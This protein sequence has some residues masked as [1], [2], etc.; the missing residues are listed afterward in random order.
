VSYLKKHQDLGLVV[1]P[2]P[3]D[4][5]PVMRQQLRE[6]MKRK[7]SESIDGTT[8]IYDDQNEG[9]DP[10]QNE[11]ERNFARAEAMLAE[12]ED[13]ED[14]ELMDPDDQVP[15]GKK[16]T[17]TAWCDSNWGHDLTTRKSISGIF[18]CVGRTPVYWKSSRQSSI[19]SS[20]MEAELAGL[21]TLAEVNRALRLT[22]G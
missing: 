21:R 5:I 17:I 14:V 18:I 16:L 2:R 7:Q 8:S 13:D 20:T 6:A 19:S 15:M 3:C 12:M 9:P 22:M 11:R 10:L 1:D 4:N